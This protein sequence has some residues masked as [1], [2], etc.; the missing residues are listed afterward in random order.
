MPEDPKWL[1]TARDAMKPKA[2]P[3]AKKKSSRTEA[4][5]ATPGTSTSTGGATATKNSGAATG[6]A[7]SIVITTSG[8][9]STETSTSTG[10]K[11]KGGKG[12]EGAEKQR[13][14]YFNIKIDARG[15][16]GN[17]AESKKP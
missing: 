8:S 3:L 13:P 6:G 12:A 15:T 5:E 9:S 17:A 10:N 16:S 7:P 4:A 11:G 14:H 2:S 1:S